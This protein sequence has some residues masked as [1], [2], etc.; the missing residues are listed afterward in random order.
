[1]TEFGIVFL[2]LFVVAAAFAA[3]DALGGSRHR[4]R[5]AAVA[6][7]ERLTALCGAAIYV[8]LL[9]VA[10]TV[11]QIGE[12]L[13]AHY[14][15]GF[16]L[17]PPVALKLWTTG[18]RFAYYYR[19][20]LTQHAAGPPP[21]LLR[22]VVAPLVV[23]STIAVFVTGVELWAF[24][25]AFG[26]GWMAAHTVSAVI[27]VLSG[28]AHVIAHARRS[29]ATVIEEISARSSRDAMTRRS[30]IVS[31]LVLGLAVAMASLF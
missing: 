17:I 4:E 8:V 1:V 6:Q 2:V 31:T 23:A 27:M 26:D 7:N 13:P 11:L 3:L 9:A 18:S 14:F 21:W 16:L 24:G 5:E 25:L 15:V 30:I 10:V 12:L 28:A 29:A 20:S 22:F 19:G